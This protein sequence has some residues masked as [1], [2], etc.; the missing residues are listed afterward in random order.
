MVVAVIRPKKAAFTLSNIPVDSDFGKWL[1]VNLLVVAF[2]FG[3]C[4]REFRDWSYVRNPYPL[5][6]LGRQCRGD[7]AGDRHSPVN[8]SPC[9]SPANGRLWDGRWSALRQGSRVQTDGRRTREVS[10]YWTALAT[11]TYCSK[12]TLLVHGSGWKTK[13]ALSLMDAIKYQVYIIGCN[14]ANIVIIFVKRKKSLIV[15]VFDS[16]ETDSL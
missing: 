13:C 6:C 9:T 16:L 8:V 5:R 12:I 15:F 7:Q 3:E 10:R 14:V 2:C 1:A 11:R 4:L